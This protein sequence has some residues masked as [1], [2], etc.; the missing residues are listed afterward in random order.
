MG[1]A[2]GSGSKSLSKTDKARLLIDAANGALSEGDPIGAL[3]LLAK[4]EEQDN[5]LAEIHHSKALAFF[6][7]REPSMALEEARRAVTINPN[8]TD[9]NNTL[10]KLLL[11]SG[12]NNEAE[13]P[14]LLAVADPLYRESFKAH[15]NLAILYYRQEHHQKSIEHLNKAIQEAPDV[16]CVAYYYRG[17]IFL[18][19]GQFRQAELDYGKATKKMCAGFMEAHL[20]LGITFE[21]DKRYDQARKKFLD[22][23]QNFPNSK[24]AEQAVERLRYLP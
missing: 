14:L 17:H 12:R 3:Q 19:A 10:G 13:K 23:Q 2:T 22:I 1:C 4:A 24:I 15:T 20:A 6:A 8:Y 16:A 5:S 7:K 18:R 21:R 11:D 9:A